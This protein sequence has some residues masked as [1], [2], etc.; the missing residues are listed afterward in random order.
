MNNFDEQYISLL[1][2]ILKNGTKKED[3]TGVGTI[4]SFGKTMEIDISES[5]PLLTLRK[6]VPKIFLEETLFFL[7]GSSD[8]KVLENK[9]IKIWT[10]N[11]SRE[12]LDQRGLHHLPEGDMGLGYGPQWRSFGQGDPIER[13]VDQVSQVLQGLRDDPYSRRHVITAWNP[14]ALPKVA[15]P[16][17][18]ITYQFVVNGDKLDCCF[19]MRSNDVYLGLPFNIAQYAML[20]Y[21]FAKSCNRKPGK[22]VYFCADAHIYTNAIEASETLLDKKP[23]ESP[24]MVITVPLEKV[25]DVFKLTSDDFQIDNY[26]NHGNG[27]KVTMAI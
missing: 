10:G 19:Y 13:A 9:G 15:L 6:I 20:T 17:C 16:P 14:L 5:F 12:F 27:P 21:I 4:S 26:Q 18:H 22:L 24:L 7:G 8:T 25:S 11:T 2:D 3:R 1:K 23:F